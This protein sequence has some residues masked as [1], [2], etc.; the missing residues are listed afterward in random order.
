MLD[1]YVLHLT[2][3]H[4]MIPAEPLAGIAREIGSGIAL[5]PRWVVR[6]CAIAWG[7]AVVV[8]VIYCADL[9]RRGRLSDLLGT[10]GLMMST[11]CL[12]PALAW[13]G[14]KRIRFT[15]IRKIMLKHLR[16]PHCGYDIRELP[17]APEDNATVCPECGCAW[18]LDSHLSCGGRADD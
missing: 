13:Y 8:Y 4:G 1:P 3:Q 17:T 18:I 15:R 2:R 9:L 6:V 12:V 7:L 11:L 16:C 10:P 5:F 14:T